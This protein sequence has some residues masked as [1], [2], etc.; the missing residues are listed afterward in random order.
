M[1]KLKSLLAVS[2][3]SLTTAFGALSANEIVGKW[4]TIDDETKK[5]RSVVQIW[6]D[7][8]G[9]AWGKIVDLLNRAP[10]E[11]AD[12]VCT[13]CKG[14]D[15]GKKIKGM[16]ILKNLKKDGNE[17]TGGTITD[18]KSGKVYKCKIEAVEGG[19]VLKVRGFI[20]FSLIGRTQKWYKM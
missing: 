14:S 9:V 15:N 3:F 19:K 5:A 6:V 1:T 18:P 11:E 10:D 16:T 13:K 8:N 20:G 2:L 4:K 17:W 12:P 7:G